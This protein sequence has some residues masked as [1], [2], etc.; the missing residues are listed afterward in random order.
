MPP[1]A[2]PLALRRDA[3]TGLT[4][5]VMAPTEDCFAVLTPFSGEGHRSLYLS[6]LGRDLAAA[7]TA[8]ARARLVIGSAIS[9]GQAVALYEA[10]RKDLRI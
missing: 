7:E 6:L 2:A 9:D 8:A 10:Y 5:V 3:K 4:G 1:L